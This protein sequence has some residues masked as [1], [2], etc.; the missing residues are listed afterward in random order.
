MTRPF[1]PQGAGLIYHVMARGNNKM[2]IFRDDLD[3]VRFLD[4][5]ADVAGEFEIDSWVICEMPNHY[6]WVLRTRQPNLSLAMQHLNGRYAQWW[7]K[8]HG[9][10]GHVLQA[11]FK[12]QVVEAT[13]YL[14]RLCR[15]VLLNPVRA[16]LCAHPSEWRWSSYGDLVSGAPSRFVD[17]ASLLALVDSDIA[18]AR[19]RLVDY[20]GPDRDP[21]M[22]A[23]I[24][25]DRRI[26]GTSA[27]AEQ[28]RQ[29][30]RTASREVPARERRTGTPALVEILATA[31]HA[32][33]G[34][35][36]GIRRA[37]EDGEYSFVDIARCTG[38]S[39]RT[40]ARFAMDAGVRRRPGTRRRRIGDLTSG[41]DGMET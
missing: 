33:L 9:H 21:D 10:V 35:A 27:F 25:N 7:N 23:F 24:R 19:A 28:F 12:A 13:V 38:L 3:L 2:V 17:T 39:E 4:I 40:V 31:V 18:R 8:R 22:E 16:G 37:R 41:N 26:I 32:G 14:V 15:Y 34:L 29:Q 11:R 30:A 6:H 5:L 36:E 1:R 20:V